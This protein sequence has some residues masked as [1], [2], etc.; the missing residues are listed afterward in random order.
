MFK[1]FGYMNRGLTLS[2][3]NSDLNILFAALSPLAYLNVICVVCMR[4]VPVCSQIIV[5]RI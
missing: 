1:G 4:V 2:V 3:P 5:S